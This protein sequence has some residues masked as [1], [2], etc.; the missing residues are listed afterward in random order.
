MV[1]AMKQPDAID[2]P[3]VYVRISW[4]FCADVDWRC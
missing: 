4:A 3:D 1:N 2:R